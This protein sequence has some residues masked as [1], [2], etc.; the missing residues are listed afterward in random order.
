MHLIDLENLVGG[1]SA[2]DTTIERVWAAYHGGIPR[3]PMDQMIVGSSRFFARRTWWLLPEGIQRRARDGQ[4]GGE[5]AILEEIDLDHL[6]TRFRRLVIASGDGRFAELAAAARR[7]GLHVHHVTGIGRP[8][9]K[10]LTA[11][12]SHARLRV[13]EHQRRPTGWPAPPRPVADA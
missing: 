2:P 8:S 3:S 7:R 13:G 11:A 4:D 9:H 6:V 12:H 10:L 1:P 5:L